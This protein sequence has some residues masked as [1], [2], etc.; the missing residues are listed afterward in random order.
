MVNISTIF[1]ETDETTKNWK[2]YQK[3]EPVHANTDSKH[4]SKLTKVYK[5]DNIL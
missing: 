2:G 5:K 1:V 4:I 3:F